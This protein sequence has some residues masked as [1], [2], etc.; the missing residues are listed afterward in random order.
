MSPPT[1]RLFS[2]GTLRQREVQMAL[3]GRE[4][5]GEADILC[6]FVLST[7]AIDDPDVVMKSGSAEHPI[8]R[9]SDGAGEEIPGTVFT[10]SAEELL[11]ADAYETSAYA[12]IEASLKSG[13]RA[14]VYVE[15][16]HP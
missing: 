6:G 16:G 1:F 14:F 7:V 13:R 15:A 12:R 2:Y 10:V 3:F 4:L 8:L 9:R 11:Q 5:E